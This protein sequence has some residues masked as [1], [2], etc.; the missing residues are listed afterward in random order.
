[1]GELVG[2]V[3]G[4]GLLDFVLEVLVSGILFVVVIWMKVLYEV[5]VNV[6]G[7]LC[8]WEIVVG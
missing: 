2:V 7:G 5:V 6:F 1:M 8:G 4:L 3:C